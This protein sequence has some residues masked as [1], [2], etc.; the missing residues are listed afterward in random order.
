M[1]HFSDAV[2]NYFTV[3]QW[4]SCLRMYRATRKLCRAAASTYCFYLWNPVYTTRL[5][6][7][8]FYGTNLC[9]AVNRNI[10]PLGYNNTRL[11]RHKLSWRYKRVRLYFV[12]M[13]TFRFS[14]T[15]N[16]P[17]YFRYLD[18]HCSFIVECY[19]LVVLLWS[20]Y[21]KDAGLCR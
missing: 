7:Q 4:L 8:T 5:Q 20:H 12:A 1:S 10:I 14:S 3:R 11:W 6:R 2:F 19:I 21:K 9:L 13:T 16:F 15:G 17:E 18:V